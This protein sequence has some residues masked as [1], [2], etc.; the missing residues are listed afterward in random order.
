MSVRK[1]VKF[2]QVLLELNYGLFALVCF[3]NFDTS[4]NIPRKR[5]P[6]LRQIQFL[7]ND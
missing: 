1:T 2:L 7:V 4:L 5:E 6:D 3:V